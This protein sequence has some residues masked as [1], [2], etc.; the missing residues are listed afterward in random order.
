MQI[1]ILNVCEVFR[2]SAIDTECVCVC[3]CLKYI[4]M[5]E[6]DW[7]FEVV[8][9][10]MLHPIH[11]QSVSTC[12][13]IIES[14]I[15]F[16]LCFLLM[17]KMKLKGFGWEWAKFFKIH[18]FFLHVPSHISSSFAQRYQF[19]SIYSYSFYRRIYV[20]RWKIV[21]NQTNDEDKNISLAIW[22]LKIPKNNVEYYDVLCKSSSGD[23]IF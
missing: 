8:H 5:N 23:D 11:F 6:N 9:L 17:Q 3:M 14:D 16:T 7:N 1:V 15:N 22:M 13:N 19:K 2:E 20:I 21:R 12:A 10:H 18:I 4:W